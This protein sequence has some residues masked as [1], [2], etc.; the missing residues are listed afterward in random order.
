MFCDDLDFYKGTCSTITV[1]QHLLD[2]ATSPRLS[3]EQFV[4]VLASEWN[5]VVILLLLLQK[6]C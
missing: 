2:G 4:P 1:Y 3:A 5:P 6:G